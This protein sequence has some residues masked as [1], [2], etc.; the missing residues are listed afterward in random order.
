MKKSILIAL[1][2]LLSINFFSCGTSNKNLKDSSNWTGVYTGVIPGADSEGINVEVI[3][4]NDGTY[5]VDY[6]YIG[7]GD[8]VFTYVGTFKW[9]ND[10]N[11]VIL[12]DK[13][14]PPYYKVGENTLTQLD[15]SGE[16]IT[17]ALAGNYVLKKI[18]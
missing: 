11:T 3:L 18:P 8:E 5:Q 17:G 7:K 16:I 15:M 1:F 14:I 2:A 9:N 13:E 6:Q 12:D 4:N 10:G